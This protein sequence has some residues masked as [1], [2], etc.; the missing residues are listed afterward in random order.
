MEA[1][2]ACDAVTHKTVSHLSI[3]RR[4]KFRFYNIICVYI[5]RIPRS[6]NYINPWTAHVL[7]IYMC[8]ACSIEPPKIKLWAQK[9]WFICSWTTI[10]VSGFANRISFHLVIDIIMCVETLGASHRSPCSRGIPQSKSSLNENQCVLIGRHTQC[11][12]LYW[13]GI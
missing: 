10:P 5:K 12:L 6:M 13:S 11:V 8:I 4:E 1:A 2:S 3:R 9:H 7:N